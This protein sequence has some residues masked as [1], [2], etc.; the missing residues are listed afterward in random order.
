MQCVRIDSGTENQ[1]LDRFRLPCPISGRLL[2]QGGQF[3]Q[4]S[5]NHYY[6]PIGGLSEDDLR[7]FLQKSEVWKRWLDSPYAQKL[8]KKLSLSSPSSNP[9]QSVIESPLQ[10]AQEHP[11]LAIHSDQMDETTRD[12]LLEAWPSTS[13]WRVAHTHLTGSVMD[14]LASENHYPIYHGN[15]DDQIFFN[16]CR[17]VTS[18]NPDEIEAYFHSLPDRFLL[19]IVRLNSPLSQTA[20][21]LN[22]HLFDLADLAL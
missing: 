12:R 11:K 20:P 2:Y 8:S 17:Q 21:T 5:N 6:F 10:F 3:Q 1:G 7:F 14:V 4:R 9:P 22:F 15:H 18:E 19:Y 16:Y 13:C